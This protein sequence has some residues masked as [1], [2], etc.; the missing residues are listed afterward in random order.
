MSDDD[1]V[2]RRRAAIAAWTKRGTRLGYLAFAAASVAV[3]WGLLDDFTPTMGRLA[4]IGLVAGCVLL[5]PSIVVSY[6]VKAAE[7][8]DREL[9][10]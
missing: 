6:M 8:H 10:V 5:A 3:A 7:K 9:G 1:P 2:R 4:T